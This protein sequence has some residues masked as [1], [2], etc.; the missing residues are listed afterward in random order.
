MEKNKKKPR[1][2]VSNVWHSITFLVT[3]Y[4][5]DKTPATKPASGTRMMLLQQTTSV[6][7]L[8]VFSKS[9]FCFKPCSSSSTRLSFMDKHTNSSSSSSSLKQSLKQ[10]QSPVLA[11]QASSDTNDT[12][13]RFVPIYQFVFFSFYWILSAPRWIFCMSYSSLCFHCLLVLLYSALIE[14]LIENKYKNKYLSWLVSCWSW[15]IRLFDVVNIGKITCQFMEC[16]RWLLVYWEVGN[17]AVCYAK[18]LQK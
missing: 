4:S 8:V 14:F 18:Q 15:V 16:P 3:S 10:Y 11:C 13:F 2:Q 5:T 1:K 9:D 7:R 12:S 6:P 17:W